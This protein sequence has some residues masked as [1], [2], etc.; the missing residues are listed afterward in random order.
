MNKGILG[1]LKKMTKNPNIR[2]TESRT[3]R[4]FEK[5]MVSI[6]KKQKVN[7]YFK[8]VYDNEFHMGI[9]SWVSW[10]YNLIKYLSRQI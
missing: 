6:L 4:E 10:F 5:Q 1:I 3:W 2:K 9:H 8:N 7:D